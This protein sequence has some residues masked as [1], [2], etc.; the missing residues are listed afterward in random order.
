MAE[1]QVPRGR[2]HRCP[3]IAVE[4]QIGVPMQSPFLKIH[5]QKGKVVERIAARDSVVEFQGVEQHRRVIDKRDVAQVEI[6]VAAAHI[7][8]FAARNQ[9]AP[10]R[11]ETRTSIG[12][13]MPCSFALEKIG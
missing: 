9:Q 2:H 5:Q 1:R 4:N 6:A 12:R 10:H 13:Q 7:A 3:K 8:G 11:P